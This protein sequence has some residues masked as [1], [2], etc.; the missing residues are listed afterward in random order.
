MYSKIKPS[1]V[2]VL[3]LA[4]LSPIAHAGK[5]SI[6]S[7][8]LNADEAKLVTSQ[9]SRAGPEK[10]EGV[11]VPSKSDI[12]ALE[13]HLNLLKQLEST[14]CCMR[15]KIE[16]RLSQY[17]LQYAGIILGGRKLIYINASPADFDKKM[18]RV[19]GERRSGPVLV[20]D[21]G[22]NFWGAI[23]DPET[24]SFRDLAFNGVA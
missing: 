22:K 11:W 18:S 6:T 16:G 1:L 8:V 4:M 2:L 5:E 3:T 10:V 20:C 23:Y 17:Q 7:T 19:T 9:C 15:G 24:Q 14:A 21:G 13:K 12:E